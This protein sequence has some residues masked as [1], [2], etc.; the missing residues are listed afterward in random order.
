MTRIIFLIFI[1]TLVS[2]CSRP[3]NRMADNKVLCDPQTGEAYIVAPG[4]VD[5]AFVTRNKN[6]DKL[7]NN[8]N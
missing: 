6:L 8:Q 5:S 7:C 2:A 3:E 1:S 4:F